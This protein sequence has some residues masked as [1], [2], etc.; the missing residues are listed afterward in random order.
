VGLVGHGLRER[1]VLGALDGGRPEVGGVAIRRYRCK[2]CR[3][4]VAV[5]PRGLLPRARYLA[6]AI[7]T[8]LVLW[9]VGRRPAAEVRR[10]VSPFAHVGASSAT[11]WKSLGRWATAPPWRAPIPAGTSRRAAAGRLVAWLAAHAPVAS[12]SVAADAVSGAPFAALR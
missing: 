7:V 12:G 2:R 11:R 1:V 5:L 4:V 9:A 3:A 10:A 8:A 6:A